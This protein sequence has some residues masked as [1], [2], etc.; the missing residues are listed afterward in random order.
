MK[1]ILF[2]FHKSTTNPGPVAKLLK[3]RGYDLDIRVPRN[4]DLLPDTMDEHQAAISFGGSVS[5]NDSETLPF[6]RTE[7]D[8]I[9]KVIESGKPFLG[10]C[11]GAQLLAKALGGKVA[12]HSEAKVEIGYHPIIPTFAGSKYFN[13]NLYFYHWN[14]EGFEPPSDAVKLAS[15]EI[16]ENQAFR[17][18]ENAYGVQFHP[19]MSRS[20]LE[21]WAATTDSE[22]EKKLKLPGAQS[23]EEQIDKHSQYAPVVENWL[24]Q[25]FSFWLNLETPKRN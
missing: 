23:W 8:W 1:K 10:I 4:G 19:E 22:T 16:F 6:I 12:R 2:V 17:Y 3:Q 14:G 11:L 9:P 18:G 24:E 7:L 25:F 15:G 5:A 20:V 13:S 21:E